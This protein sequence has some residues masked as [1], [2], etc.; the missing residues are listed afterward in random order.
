MKKS[1][2][3]LIGLCIFHATFAQHPKHEF[4]ATWLTS[5]MR[6]DWPKSNNIEQQKESLCKIFDV[7]SKGNMNAACLQV[8]SFSDALYK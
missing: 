5:G 3:I 4:R 1:L 2:I 7:M 6:I 8:R